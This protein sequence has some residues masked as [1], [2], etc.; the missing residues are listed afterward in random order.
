[1]TLSKIKEKGWDFVVLQ[2][3]GQRPAFADWE[4][5]EEVYPFARQLSEAVRAANSQARVIF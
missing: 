1:V 5:Q 2:E 4:V 3:Q